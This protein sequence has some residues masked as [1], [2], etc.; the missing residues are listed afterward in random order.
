MITE[1]EFIAMQEYYSAKRRA[2]SWYQQAM[3]QTDHREM[4]SLLVYWQYA[5]DEAND[6][7]KQ[8]KPENQVRLTFISIGHQI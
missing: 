7:W 5:A 3:I 4:L 6:W 8:I 2:L 1:K